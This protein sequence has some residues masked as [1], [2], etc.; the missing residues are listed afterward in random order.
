MRAKILLGL[1]FGLIGFIPSSTDSNAAEYVYRG[2]WKTVNRQLDG[3]MTCVVTPTA[4]HA[5]QG[6]FH[7]IW[8]GVEFDYTVD[9]MG[10]PNDLKG[11][12]MIDGASYEWRAWI[13]RDAM[14]A[15]FAGSRYEGSFDLKRV[16]DRDVARQAAKPN[17]TAASR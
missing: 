4:K 7:G 10:P 15:N 6:R 13:T 12:A 5:W 9:F 8:Q 17:S 16:T 1:L 3:E 11:S 14:K 2:T